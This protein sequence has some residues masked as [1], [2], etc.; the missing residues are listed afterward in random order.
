MNN[1]DFSTGNETPPNRSWDQQQRYL[2]ILCHPVGSGED[3]KVQEGCPKM[4][5]GPPETP[6][7]IA[8]G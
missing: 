3:D 1:H 8:Y 2:A 4:A 6:V 7:L 5:P